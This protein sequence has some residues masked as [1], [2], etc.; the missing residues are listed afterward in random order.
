M[1]NDFEGAV[2]FYNEALQ[3]DPDYSDAYYNKGVAYSHLS[4]LD[5]AISN[6]SKA[7]ELNKEYADAFYQRS[8]AYLDNGENY[9]ALSDAEQLT[10]LHPDGFKGYFLKGLVLEQLQRYPEAQVAFT[11]AIN[12]D[13]TNTDLFVNRANIYYYLEDFEAA[14]EDLD[15]AE[16]LNPEEANIY[17]LKSLISFD[18]GHIEKALE[19]VEKAIALDAGQAYFYNNRGLYFLFNNELEKGLED[20][21]FSIKQNNRNLYALR[22]KGI[23]YYFK[24]DKALAIKYLKDVHQKAPSIKLTKKYLDLSQEL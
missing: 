9:K 23:Y 5:Q 18:Q 24:K 15:K 13:S 8:L 14:Q 3:L 12:R 19:W 22:N 4:K 20:I 2:D 10:A 1:E 11:E 21:N 6:F 17:N 7:I 16:L